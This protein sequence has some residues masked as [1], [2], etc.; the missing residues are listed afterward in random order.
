VDD[1]IE[2]KG[3]ELTKEEFGQFISSVANKGEEHEV[4]VF[5]FI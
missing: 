5:N 1:S 3:I 4:I 2:S